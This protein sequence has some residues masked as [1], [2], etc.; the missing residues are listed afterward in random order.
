MTSIEYQNYQAAVER[1]HEQNKLRPGLCGSSLK[2]G[3]ESEPYFSWQPCECCGSTLGGNREDYSFACEDGSE[4]EASIC[5]DCVYYLAY[6]QLDD[7]TM[8]EIEESTK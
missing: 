6:G 8:M 5:Q 4:L 7:A 3:E 1:F 2:N